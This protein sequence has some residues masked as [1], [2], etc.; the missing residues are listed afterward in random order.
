M[1]VNLENI[2]FIEYN[3]DDYML[4]IIVIIFLLNSFDNF[5]IENVD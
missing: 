2:N 5:L 3:N 4:K 1:A